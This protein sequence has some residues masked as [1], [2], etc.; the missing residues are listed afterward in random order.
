MS[1]PLHPVDASGDAPLAARL[2]P[3][4]A[5]PGVPAESPA[6]DQAKRALADS[7]R[8][9]RS[10]FD[11]MLHGLAYC[12]V[13]FDGDRPVDWR[14]LEVNPAF[15]RLTGLRDARGRLVSELVPG[16]LQHDA[17]LL[18][19][20]G[21][22]ARGGAAEQFERQLV[23]LGRWVRVSI[24]SPQPGHVVALF[25][26][27]TERHEA[28]IKTRQAHALFDRLIDA[29]IVGMAVVGMGGTVLV[30]N[31][32][33]LGLLGLARSG[34]EAEGADWREMTP[35]EWQRADQAA[36]ADLRRT[37]VALPF[38]KEV[39]RRDGS[40]VPVLMALTTLPGPGERVLMVVLDISEQ[41]SA[42]RALEKANAALAARTREAEDANA[43]KS[44]FLS[45][46]SHELRTPLHTLLGYL[47]L[48]AKG[49]RGDQLRQAVAGERSAVQLERLI[50]D[51][52][53]FSLDPAQAGTLD[54]APTDLLQL[55]A[56]V[57]EVGRGAAL[58][59]GNR[60]ML[61]GD[62]DLP[63]TL[64][65]D[66]QR[67]SQVLH[68]LVDNACKYTRG[69]HV[70]LHVER[71]DAHASV[72]PGQLDT[73]RFAVVDTGAGV[74]PQDERRIFDAFQRGGDT[75]LQPGMGLGLAI[76]RH[77]VDAMGG[78][79]D[80]VSTPGR[81]CS[82][83]FTLVLPVLAGAASG[84]APDLSGCETPDHRQV[85][86]TR[87]LLVLDDIA[88]NRELLR[89]LCGY[90]GYRIVEAGD[91]DH[92]MALI[93]TSWPPVDAVLVDQ[94]MPVADGWAFLRRLRA[95]DRFGELPLVLVSAS[96]PRVP[97]DLPPDVH[98]DLVLGKPFD[99]QVL[100]CFLC[101][102]LLPG[103]ADPS[104]CAVS[105]QVAG[106]LQMSRGAAPPR[107]N[108]ADLAEL[109]DLLRLGRLPRLAVW[110][111]DLARREPAC[112]AW[113]AEVSRCCE[114]VDLAQLE[115]LADR[116]R[117]AAHAA[118]PAD[119]IAGAA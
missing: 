51:L 116:V 114:T 57:E 4:V 24:Y 1:E 3:P 110:A 111:A 6:L 117:S 45:S 58:V 13:V 10:L 8:M 9:Y 66:G 73:L 93:E 5:V 29:N 12:R 18:E 7:E 87:T 49:A 15:E 113:A 14:Y 119:R 40:R 17:D 34:F 69:G 55:L 99:P 23:S 27:V 2:A 19:I 96:P 78:T 64:L 42:Q 108:G 90:W 106:P 107:L 32:C 102:T 92:A 97:A 98:F 71:V 52:L 95:S 84:D 39:L 74:A 100:R 68:N 56:Q 109:G 85:A 89:E 25:D 47:R 28:E 112:A 86:A 44:R 53:S 62:P 67:L 88:A 63:A 80:L 38:E 104:A 16:L 77:W 20:Y 75:Q 31:D 105:V 33:Y 83:H 35:P 103:M 54:P 81:G 37:G 11:H 22:V 79:L 46:V 94:F 61:L 115:A 26:D 118:A 60:F 48:L 30:A 101:R 72:A 70:T 59:H 50:K 21:R 82:F 41:R 36:L 43:A 76:A 65:V 91:V